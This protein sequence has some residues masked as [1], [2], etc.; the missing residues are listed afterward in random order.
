MGDI[1]NVLSRRHKEGERKCAE[2]ATKLV[3]KRRKTSMDWERYVDRPNDM[4]VNWVIPSAA[5]KTAH[6]WE[7]DRMSYGR[8]VIQAQGHLQ[9][10]ILDPIMGRGTRLPVSQYPTM[11]YESMGMNLAQCLSVY[12]ESKRYPGN[13]ICIFG[14]NTEQLGRGGAQEDF[15]RYQNALTSYQAHIEH[16]IDEDFLRAENRVYRRIDTEALNNWVGNREAPRDGEPY[17][18]LYP[19]CFTWRKPIGAKKG[20]DMRLWKHVFY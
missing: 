8:G 1:K 7:E 5:R 17:H 4:Y 2:Q 12:E 9:G 19:C 13:S 18:L 15:E 11:V 14:L 10:G 3:G 6:Y 20:Y 16:G